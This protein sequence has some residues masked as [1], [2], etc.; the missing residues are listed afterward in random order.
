MVHTDGASPAR[1]QAPLLND[2]RFKLCLFAFNLSGGQTISTAPGVLEPTW[3]GNVRLARIA[4]RAGFEALIPVGRWIGFG[5]PSRYHQKSFESYTWAAGLGAL[6]DYSMVTATGHVPS[7][8]PIVAAKQSVTVDHITGGRFALNL[9]SGW[10]ITEIEFFGA[11]ML[12]HDERYEQAAEWLELCKRL[13]RDDGKFDFAGDFYTLKNAS[14]TP[15][16]VQE[17]HPVVISAGVSPRGQRFAAEHADVAFIG[18]E[19][20]EDLGKNAA[21]FRRL[22]KEEFGRDIVV[23][24]DI[25]ACCFPTDR[26]AQTYAKL[27]GD[28][29]DTIAAGN[30]MA[31]MKAHTQ[32]WT[33]EQYARFQRHFMQSYGAAQALGSPERVARFFVDVEAA[34]VDGA[35][36]SIMGHWEENLRLIA[37]EVL[38]RL[39]EA[40]IRRPHSERLAELRDTAGTWQGNGRSDS[41]ESMPEEPRGK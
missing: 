35:A 29:G 9:V 6:T 13:W 12:G 30:N 14:S 33:E 11:K 4:D 22:A 1:Q 34:G 25:V 8:H 37:D 3:E 36:F 2:N 26:E 41:L 16:P 28:M 27:I 18:G 24:A 15:R 21:A 38:P 31:I 32:T 19:T 17:P 23:L 39:E 40:G 10:F 7:T 20:I 5:G